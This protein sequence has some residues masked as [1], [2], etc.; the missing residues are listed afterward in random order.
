MSTAEELEKK[1]KSN[2]RKFLFGLFGNT[3]EEA[4][5]L[6]AQAGNKY[7]QL[8]KWHDASRC[9]AESA[10]LSEKNKDYM[11][12]ATNLVE[13]SNCL[14]KINPNSD[15]FVDPLIRATQVYNIQGRF[16][17]S[18][19]IFKNV[20]ETM[21][22]RLDYEGAMVYYKK[23]AET[24]ELDEFGK[25]AGSQCLLKY[26]DLASTLTD[27]YDEAINIYE[28]Q[29]RKNTKN[30]LL[31]YGVKDLLFKA[32]VLRILNSDPTDAKIALEKY[33]TWDETFKDTREGRFLQGLIESSESNDMGTF[34]EKMK[35][36][37]SFARLDNWKIKV[38]YK[39][40]IGYRSGG[41][42]EY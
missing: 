10:K 16:A 29:A 23:S 39:V 11:F 22:E 32:G 24:Y 4:Q 7:K 28:A 1:A 40:S 18:G 27:K 12:T 13:L 14:K 42:L 38:L 5:E 2:S 9:F 25:V 8:H 21:E 31:K 3:L 34:Q 20:A 35:D 6:Y 19:R 17:Q 15:D 41:L 36:F 26:A 37:D 33:D 30:D